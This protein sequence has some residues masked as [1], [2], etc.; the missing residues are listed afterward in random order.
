MRH[1]PETDVNVTSGRFSAGK[2]TLSLED[3]AHGVVTAPPSRPRTTATPPKIRMLVPW[4]PHINLDCRS[5]RRP[6]TDFKT[7]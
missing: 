3:L 6:S 2:I 7:Q 4:A 5:F 1:E